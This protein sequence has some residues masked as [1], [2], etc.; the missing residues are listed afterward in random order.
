MIQRL[1]FILWHYFA[2][3]VFLIA[4]SALGFGVFRFF[5]KTDG[6]LGKIEHAILLTWG[7]GINI[8]VLQALAISGHLNVKW[9]V[10]FLSA[11]L[12]VGIFYCK[13]AWPQRLQLKKVREKIPA[14]KQWMI[15]LTIALAFPLLL[16][17]LKP[18]VDWDGVMYHLPHA[19]EWMLTGHLDVHP[20]LR[21]PWFP[22]NFDL[23]FSA[24]LALYDDTFAILLHASAGWIVGWLIFH[25]GMKYFEFWTACIATTIWFHLAGSQFDNATN[26]MGLTLFIVASMMSFYL[27]IRHNHQTKWLWMAAF[28]LGVAIGTKYQAL[29]Y[30]PVFCAALVFF[31]CKPRQWLAVLLLI[32]IPCIYW[33]GRN[34]LFTGDPFNPLGGKIFGF[35]DWN[36]GDY[37]FQ[38]DDITRNHQWPHWL[39]WAAPLALFNQ[40]IADSRCKKLL[41]IF[42]SY[43]FICWIATSHYPRYL[44]PAYPMLALMAGCGWIW[45]FRA[46]HSWLE[47]SSTNKTFKIAFSRYLFIAFWVVILFFATCTAIIK[48]YKYWGQVASTPAIRE[49][50]LQKHISGYPVLSYIQKMPEVKIYQFGLEDALYYAPS[51]TWGDHFGQGRYRD[52]ASLTPEA[53]AQRLSAQG[54]NALL[55][56]TERWPDIDS[57]PTFACYFSLLKS[58]TPVKLYKIKPSPD[59]EC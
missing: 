7:M 52:F 16:M 58:E 33:Y 24:A 43:A 45:L 36:L 40:R 17:P 14:S 15:Y 59:R 9:I 29:I 12:L 32:S 57:K 41:V 4:C 11:E 42:C 27:W 10:L 34:L 56:H 31:K 26:D 21:Y 6:G 49:E 18:P 19:K 46:L 48:S 47:A 5:L 35:T 30:F 2:V 8:C 1:E 13:N 3:V 20:W 44:M 54:F 37:Q 55:I 39:L 38:M 51:Q 22:Y 25:F 53:L 28:L 23:L 50:I